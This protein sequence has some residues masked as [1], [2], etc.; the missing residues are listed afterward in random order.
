MYT[1]SVSAMWSS[2]GCILTQA[3]LLQAVDKYHEAEKY[4][5]EHR[6]AGCCALVYASNISRIRE[7]VSMYK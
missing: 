4:G 1:A 6:A 3:L 5:G 2:V 7:A